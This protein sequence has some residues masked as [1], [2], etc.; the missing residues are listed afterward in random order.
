MARKKTLMRKSSTYSSLRG[1]ISSLKSRRTHSDFVPV[2]S[3]QPKFK[4]VSAKQEKSQQNLSLNLANISISYQENTESI[5]KNNSSSPYIQACGC[6]I[7]RGQ[8]LNLQRTPLL[9]NAPTPTRKSN[10]SPAPVLIPNRVKPRIQG[11]FWSK[12]KKAAKKVGK[13]ISKGAKKVG[14]GIKKVGKAIGKGAK[15]AGSWLKK[16]GKKVWNAIKK[17]GN[18]IW[19]GAKWIGRQ[20]WSKLKGIYARAVN[21]ITQLPTRLK[22]LILGIWEGVKSLK[23]WSLEWWKSLGKASTW[24]DFL[25]WLGTNVVYLLEVVGVGEIYETLADFIKFNT[26]P[27][28]ST[29][30]A[31]ARVVFGNSIDYSLV[32]VDE[33]ALLGPSW[34]DRA[35]VSFHTINSWGPLND[36]TLIHELTHVWQYQKMGAIYMPRAIH[37]QN[38][39]EGY[40]YDSNELRKRKQARQGLMSFN[41]EQQGQ[42]LADYYILKTTGKV[43]ITT[44]VIEQEGKRYAVQEHLETSQEL[45]DLYE[46]FV[47]DVHR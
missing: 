15:K 46:Y 45:L 1:E 28:N 4:L 19:T 22:R 33:Y 5:A 2:T 7:C 16:T 11:G 8:S 13:A 32:R 29:E 37:A 24:K 25:K 43:S 10:R 14:Q 38:T 40:Y 36:H 39:P 42:V 31:K 18:L 21:W 27:L 34:T 6:P 35:Y 26:R 9:G 23:P 30:I 3:I 44:G 47:A 20:L 41:L 12:V 17:A